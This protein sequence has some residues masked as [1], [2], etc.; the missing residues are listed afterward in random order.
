MSSATL[1]GTYLVGQRL[2]SRCQ[3]DRSGV[4]TDPTSIT[5]QV[6]APS[7][8]VTT[9]IPPTV[10]KESTGIYVLDWTPTAAGTWVVK[11]T[12]TGNVEAVDEG[13]AIAEA[14]LI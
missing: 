3:F 1:L 13:Q 2:T 9:N 7:G 12:A 10:V 14:S 6:K 4:L 5:C 11:W 8:T